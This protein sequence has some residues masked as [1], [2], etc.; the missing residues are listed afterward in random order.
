MTPGLDE[1]AAAPD[2]RDARATTP[3]YIARVTRQDHDAAMTR[4]RELAALHGV[5][6]AGVRT[7]RDA[8]STCWP[9]DPTR[10]RRCV[11]PRAGGRDARRRR[12]GGPGGARARARP[13]RSRTSAPAPGL[14]GL[15]LAA[16]RPA[17]RVIEVESAA[18]KCAFIERAI[19]AMGLANAEVACARA[20][21][22]EAGRGACERRDGPRAGPAPGA[23]GVRGAAAARTAARSWP[24]RARPTPA[25]VAD[26]D[27]AAE[28]LGLAP[29]RVGSSA[30]GQGP[31]TALSTST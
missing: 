29:A 18:R 2:R 5:D 15:V 3:S 24:G 20:E 8:C 1:P 22:W 10:P 13:A 14:P 19:E 30:R 31:S 26:G 25:E 4:L 21:A 28:A 11:D 17:V 12:P 6:A 9:T 27:A 16:A 23:R 7:A